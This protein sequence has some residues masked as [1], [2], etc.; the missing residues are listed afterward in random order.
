MNKANIIILMLSLLV[1]QLFSFGICHAEGSTHLEQATRIDRHSL[2]SRN[3]PVVNSMD[4]LSSLSVGNGELAYTV[5]A[6]GLQ[7]FPEYYAGGIC[8]GT[9]SQWGWHSFPNTEGYKFS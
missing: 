4:T 5:D 6:T 9:Q 7:S 2:V 1:P 8:L 3:N